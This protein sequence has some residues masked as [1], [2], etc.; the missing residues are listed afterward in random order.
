MLTDNIVSLFTRFLCYDKI[1]YTNF[2]SWIVRMS[3]KKV[4]K[5]LIYLREEEKTL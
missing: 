1:A 4:N 2:N 3:D 5:P